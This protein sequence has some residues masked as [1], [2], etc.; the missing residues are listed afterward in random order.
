MGHC[1][2]YDAVHD[3]PFSL[4][5]HLSD[6]PEGDRQYKVDAVGYGD[7]YG[8]RCDFLYIGGTADSHFLKNFPLHNG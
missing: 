2:L 4:F 3:V 6:H 7:S 8:M 5:H 1:A